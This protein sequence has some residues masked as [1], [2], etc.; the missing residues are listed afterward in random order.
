MKIDRRKYPLHTPTISH[1]ILGSTLATP[2]YI[3]RTKTDKERP[4][5]VCSKKANVSGMTMLFHFG[6]T[7]YRGLDRMVM[8]V[9]LCPI[10]FVGKQIYQQSC[11]K[12]NKNVYKFARIQNKWK[13][14]KWIQP[15]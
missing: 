1:V 4:T 2:L 12:M 3:T 9:S 10:Y 11:V 6:W 15:C 7:I 13:Q 5:N 14:L 8:S